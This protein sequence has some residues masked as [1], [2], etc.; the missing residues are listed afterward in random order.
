MG[1][2][3]AIKVRRLSMAD[4]RA[5]LSKIAKHAHV[6]GEYFFVG[7]N[8]APMIGIMNAEEMEDYLELHDPAVQAKIEKSNE[9]IRAGRTRPAAQLL[10]EARKELSRKPAVRRRPKR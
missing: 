9:D 2:R 3:K 10:E 7:G 6:N 8:G 4:A 1:K 5:S